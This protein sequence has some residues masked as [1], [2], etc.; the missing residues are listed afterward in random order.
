MTFS[1]G[2]RYACVAFLLAT[3]AQSKSPIAEVICEP[4][5]RM[6]DKLIGQFGA[7]REATG[8]RGPEQLMEVWT[9][10]SGDWTM[11]VTYSTG[12][13]CIVAMGQNWDSRA[14]EK[15]ARG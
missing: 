10:S 13:S 8:L 9:S 14:D 12:T 2:F 6:Y 5:Q 11:V 7:T 1:N 3:P 4:T 15:P